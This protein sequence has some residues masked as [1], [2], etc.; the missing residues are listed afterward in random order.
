[1]TTSSAQWKLEKVVA[2]NRNADEAVFYSP[3]AIFTDLAMNEVHAREVTAPVSHFGGDIVA[4]QS[5]RN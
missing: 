1:M 4:L 2:N 3:A 5:A